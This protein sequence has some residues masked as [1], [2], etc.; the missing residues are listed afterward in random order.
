MQSGEGGAGIISRDCNGS[1]ILHPGVRVFG[2]GSAED[3]EFA[4][5]A[6]GLRLA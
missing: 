6:E 3:A 4:T 2:C 5:C 1:V